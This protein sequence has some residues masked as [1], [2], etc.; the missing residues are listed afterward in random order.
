MEKKHYTNNC[1]FIHS[2]NSNR[3]LKGLALLGLNDPGQAIAQ[4]DEWVFNPHEE[5]EVFGDLDKVVLPRERIL[6]RDSIRLY[7]GGADMCLA[8]TT[9]SLF[10]LPIWLRKH[11]VLT[12]GTHT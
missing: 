7:Y 5:C 6:D 11:N 4:S 3:A 1:P 10:E 9:S 12:G 8:I 2:K